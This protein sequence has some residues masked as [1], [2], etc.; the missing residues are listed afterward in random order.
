MRIGGAAHYIVVSA[1][2]V[3]YGISAMISKTSYDFGNTSGHNSDLW[4]YTCTAGK[5]TGA[6]NSGDT[7]SGV[8]RYYLPDAR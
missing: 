3:S 5:E 4:S 6:D 2:T 7:Q 1:K 8:W